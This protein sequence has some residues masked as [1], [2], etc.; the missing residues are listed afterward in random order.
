MSRR[1]RFRTSFALTMLLVTGG[2]MTAFALLHHG[3]PASAAAPGDEV[4]ARADRTEVAFIVDRL[5]NA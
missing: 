1:F 5:E 2:G 4:V 3:E